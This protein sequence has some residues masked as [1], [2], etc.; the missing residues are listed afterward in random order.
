MTGSKE[1]LLSLKEGWPSLPLLLA[2][3]SPKAAA[4]AWSREPVKANSYHI[5]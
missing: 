3:E 5:S 1:E 2:K 4:L